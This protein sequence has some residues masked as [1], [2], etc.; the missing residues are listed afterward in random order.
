MRSTRSSSTRSSSTRSSSTRPSRST[1][2]VLAATGA[3]LALAL[4]ACG[5]SD[6]TPAAAASSVQGVA[7]RHNDADVTFVNDMAP[8]HSGAIEM[9]KLAQGQAGSAEVKDLAGRIAA[10]QEPEI[11]KM[12]AMAA[13][14]KITLDTGAGAMTGMAGGGSDDVT[15]LRPLT[16]AAF[17]REFLTRMTAHHSSAVEMA[18]TELAQGSNPQAKELAT[19]IVA[20]QEKELA[21]MRGLLAK[22]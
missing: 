10:E 13:T 11:A 2:T 18:R 12:K 5:T 21:E 22:A 19:A 4:S 1:S 20:A 6:A 16:G 14:W 15:A 9:A 17:D 3:V 7:V 8:H